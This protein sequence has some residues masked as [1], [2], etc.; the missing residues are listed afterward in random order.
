MPEP[1]EAHFV[2]NNESFSSLYRQAQQ[3]FSFSSSLLLIMLLHVSGGQ[4]IHCQW[5][6]PAIGNIGNRIP[7]N[8]TAEDRARKW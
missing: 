5:T 1:L 2:S 3:N 7:I 4:G 8:A 6:E